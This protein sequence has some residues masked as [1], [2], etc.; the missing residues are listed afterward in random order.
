MHLY[1]PPIPA[2]NVYCDKLKRVT[3]RHLGYYTIGKKVVQASASAP[4]QP[5]P[6]PTSAPAETG[7]S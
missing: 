3:K 4:T 2:C 1:A 6:A 7:S 5:K